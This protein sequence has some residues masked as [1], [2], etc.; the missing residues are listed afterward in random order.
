MKAIR[1]DDFDV[2]ETSAHSKKQ[3]KYLRPNVIKEEEFCQVSH[4][5]PISEEDLK[6]LYKSN[7]F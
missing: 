1:G 6:T 2:I 7:V 4:H 5:P 3:T